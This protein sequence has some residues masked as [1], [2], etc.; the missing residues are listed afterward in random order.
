MSSLPPTFPITYWC[1]LLPQTYFSVNIAIKCRQNPL[2]SA[3]A[4]MEGEFHFYTTPIAPPGSEI[5]IHENPN[6]RKKFG[7]NEKKAWYIAP[8][9]QHYQTFKGIMASTGAEWISD[10]V[11]FKHRAITIPQS[12]PAN[13]ILEAARHLGSAIKQQPKKVPMDEL[14]AIELLIKL[15]LGERKQK[16]SPNSIQVSKAKQISTSTKEAPIPVKTKTLSL[17]L[18]YHPAIE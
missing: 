4:A 11:R 9:F 15:L 5:L 7:F 14:V 2:L 17:N 10:T 16:L 3:W 12:T 13:I 8:F 6:R 18:S 1:R